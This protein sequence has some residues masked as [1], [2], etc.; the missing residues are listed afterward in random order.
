MRAY[1]FQFIHFLVSRYPRSVVILSLAAAAAAGYFGV[2]RMEMIT[3]QD[4][5]LSEKLDYHKRYMDFIRRFGD[6]E[7]LYILIE[8]QEQN[9][10]IAFADAL[11]ARLSQSPDVKDIIYSF[12]STWARKFALYF[13]PENDLNQLSKELKNNE[14]NI[15]NLFAASNADEILQKISDGLDSAL[16]GAAASDSSE[17]MGGDLKTFLQVLEGKYDDPFKEFSKLE[18]SIDEQF[19]DGKKYIVTGKSILMLVMPSKDYSTLSVIDKPLQRIRADIWLTSQEFPDVVAGMTGRPVLQADEMTTTNRDMT[20]STILA[21]VCVLVLFVLFFRELVRPMLG[22]LT[23][24]IAM[25]WTYGFVA[26]TLGHLN[27]LSLVFALV[28]VG[29]GIDFGI[30]FLHRYQDELRRNFDPSAA[31]A[32]ALKHVGPGI[33]TGAITSSIA[34][35][36]ALMTDFLGL[37]ELGYV[38]GIGIIICLTAMLVTLPAFLIAYDRHVRKGESI[39]APLHIAGLRHTSRYP[40][41]LVLISLILTAFLLP[42]AFLVTFDDNILNLQADGLESVKYEHKLINESEYST[43][44][45]AFLKPDMDAVRKTVDELKKKPIVAKV[46]SLDDV[47]PRIAPS[48]RETMQSIASLL[49]AVKD[50]T[51]AMYRPNPAIRRELLQKIDGLFSSV[52][53]MKAQQAQ[54]KQG[55]IDPKMIEEMKARGLDQSQIAEQI[56]AAGT[57]PQSQ[58][59]ADP[60]DPAQKELFEQ[61]KS[62]A[63]LISPNSSIADTRMQDANELLLERPRALLRSLKRKATVK[64]PGP[65]DLPKSLRSMYIGKEGSFL[66]MAYPKK[67]IWETEPM[68]EFIAEMRKIDPNVTGAPIQVYESSRLMRDAFTNIGAYSF[69]AVGVLVFLDFLSLPITM[70]V[71]T[72]LALGVLWLVEIMGIFNVHLNLANFFAIPILIGIGVDNAVHFYHRYLEIYNVDKS[73][74]TTGSTLTLTTLT[75]ITGFGSLIF[76]S[77]KGLASLGI[78][79]ALGSATCWFACVVF[80]PALIKLLPRK[81]PDKLSVDDL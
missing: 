71:M 32:S 7:Y 44:Y 62:L 68:R 48:Q 75:T 54:M 24:L 2:E 13:V 52:A 20:K 50:A 16:T 36:L 65:E 34:F 37:A 53:Q 40:L 8:A 78:L 51:P 31:I 42:K 35:L 25:G 4:R 43:W 6:L 80:L 26:L 21:L 33:I 63:S 19:K 10:A 39:P 69:I 3:D 18:T 60:I 56:A 46:E 47:L 11:A 14:Q 81:T 67:N 55:N 22:V 41:I 57:D 77:H 1:L 79:M 64:E 28:L 12:D 45:C 70:L 58:A 66:I 49:D 15:K 59:S 17:I 73:I 74:N 23:L 29:L 61:L 72:P 5:L 9:R 76:A 27:L 38:A 30:H